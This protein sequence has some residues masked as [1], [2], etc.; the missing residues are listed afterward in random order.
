MQGSCSPG[1]PPDTHY[2]RPRHQQTHLVYWIFVL[3][4]KS[5]SPVK[6]R[7]FNIVNTCP[8]GSFDR[9]Y[10][11]FERKIYLPSASEWKKKPAAKPP[12]LF[13]GNHLASALVKYRC[14]LV[15]IM[16]RSDIT[17]FTL[18]CLILNVIHKLHVL[19]LCRRNVYQHTYCVHSVSD[20]KHILTWF[21]KKVLVSRVLNES[22]TF[23]VFF[24]FAILQ[25]KLRINY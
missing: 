7:Q 3:P 17:L 22:L 13:D 5:I 6:F 10:R 20:V 23:N 14:H 25:E 24:F 9:F 11:L 19:Q 18:W 21:E 4:I 16:V 1:V 8:H 12:I 15:K 2:R